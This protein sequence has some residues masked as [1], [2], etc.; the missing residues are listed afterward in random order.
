MNGRLGRKPCV[1]RLAAWKDCKQTLWSAVLKSSTW[2][3]GEQDGVWRDRGAGKGLTGEG[4]Q[5]SKER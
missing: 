4:K 1:S 2:R 3:E 5:A